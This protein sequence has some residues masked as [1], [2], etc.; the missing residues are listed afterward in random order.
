MLNF[1]STLLVVLFAGVTVCVQATE[2][3]PSAQPNALKEFTLAGGNTKA[4]QKSGGK[5][6]P[7]NSFSSRNRPKACNSVKSCNGL[8]ADCIAANG[9]FYPSKHDPDT[10]APSAGACATSG[11]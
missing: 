8:I 2:V 6:A 4:C 3:R 11:C 5:K 1:K 10:G 7:I 9:E